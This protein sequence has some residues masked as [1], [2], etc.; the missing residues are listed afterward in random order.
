MIRATI[1]GQANRGEGLETFELEVP[2]HPTTHSSDD[3]ATLVEGVLASIDRHQTRGRSIAHADVMQAL[4]IATA[5]QTAKHQASKRLQ[6]G[7]GISFRGL[8]LESRP[9]RTAHA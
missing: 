8:C 9:A 6:P 7:L 2:L 1:E 3:V 5:V 4:A